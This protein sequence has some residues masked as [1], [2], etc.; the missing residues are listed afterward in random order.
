MI[1]LLR[2]VRDRSSLPTV[3]RLTGH[4]DL[5]V[6]LESLRTLLELDPTVGQEYVR[7]AIADPDLRVATA[8]VDLAG[9]GGGPAMVG[10]LLGVLAPW[11]FRGRRRTVRLAALLALGRVGR[12]EA[13]PPLA[14]FFRARWAPFPV[15]AER[16]AAFESLQG[17][18]PEARARLVERGL[19]SRDQ[20]I[21]AACERLRR[22]E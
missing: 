12:P 16:R 18:P 22:S 15:L 19:R 3:R 4:P 7:R 10:A 1:A 17:Y 9:R 11:D 8:A 6:R 2:A 14:R 13:L 21:R 20:Q 5:R